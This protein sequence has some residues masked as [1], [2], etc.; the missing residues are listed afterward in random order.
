[1]PPL[2]VIDLETTGLPGKTPPHLLRIVEIGAVVIT[3]EGEILHELSV[4]IRQPREILTHPETQVSMG[5]HGIT[6]EELQEHGVDEAPGPRGAAARFRSWV[7][8]ARLRYGFFGA[9]SYNRIFDFDSFLYRP[10][11]DLGSLGLLKMPCLM[12]AT[13]DAMKRNG[14]TLRG[15]SGRA[16]NPKVGEAVEWLRGRGH[17]FPEGLR[18]HRALDDAKTEAA[19]AVAL[20][21]ELDWVDWMPSASAPGQG[22]RTAASAPLAPSPLPPMPERPPFAVTMTT[23]LV[24]VSTTGGTQPPS[25]MPPLVLPPLPFQTR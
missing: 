15:A 17:P 16:K 4:L 8:A 25:T 12:L 6:V 19:I 22:W 1:M 7:A 23:K 18:V 9:T 24:T 21:K 14:L 10:E 13:F 20:H 3:Q 5:I 2:L 11:W